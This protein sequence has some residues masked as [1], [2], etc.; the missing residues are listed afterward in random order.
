MPSFQKYGT[1][2]VSMQNRQLPPH[3]LALDSIIRSHYLLIHGGDATSILGTL[4]SGCLY[5][6]FTHQLCIINQ[7]PVASR[8]LRENVRKNDTSKA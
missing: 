4:I 8:R 1:L 2:S 7:Q 6:E 5:T 3:Q